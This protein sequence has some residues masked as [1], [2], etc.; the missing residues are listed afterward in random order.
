[1]DEAADL[2]SRLGPVPGSSPILLELGAGGGRLAFHLKA[3]F[4]LTLTDPSP[5][6]L[7]I[8]RAV[9]PECAHL[10]GDMRSLTLTRSLGGVTCSSV[11]W[12]WLIGRGSRRERPDGAT[13]GEAVDP[14][15]A[16]GGKLAEGKMG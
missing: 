7:A 12:R 11:P 3:P 6:M 8:S 4:L 1:M 5:A 15:E 10:T 13:L 9:N 14:G 16:G 2:L